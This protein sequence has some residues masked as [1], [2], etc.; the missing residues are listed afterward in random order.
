MSQGPFSASFKP[1]VQFIILRVWLKRLGVLGSTCIL[2]ILSIV[3]SI[4]IVTIIEL[5]LFNHTRPLILVEAAFIA[6]LI[7][8]PIVFII[9]DFTYKLERMEQEHRVHSSTD[10]LTQIFNRRYV[11]ERAEIELL[12][13][14]RH[15]GLFSILLLDI[16]HFKNINDRYG[17][18]AG[19]A[20]LRAVS[21]LL[22]SHVR[23]TDIVGRYGGEEFLV[24]L[25]NTD[26]TEALDVAERFR[27]NL[28]RMVVAYEHVEFQITISIGVAFGTR[29]TETV[30]TVLEAADQV[31]YQAKRNG[32]NQVKVVTLIDCIQGI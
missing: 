26:H 13:I 1:K 11:L 18:L 2:T 29:R 30:D 14:K 22:R 24:L 19:D 28:A 21:N 15:G 5:Y 20:A 12:R 7:A 3:L 23:P 16:D 8:S 27:V 6:L 32:R 31:L 9:L 10:H 25:P 17:H 4:M